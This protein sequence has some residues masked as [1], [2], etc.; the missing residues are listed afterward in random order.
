MKN[1]DDQHSP[2]FKNFCSIA[3]SSNEFDFWYFYRNINKDN[4]YIYKFESYPYHPIKWTYRLWGNQKF[5]IVVM[6]FGYSISP[7]YIFA[8][9]GV[10]GCDIEI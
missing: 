8:A 3:Y 9:V 1:Y 4:Q 7:S 6:S 2:W 5:P 10:F